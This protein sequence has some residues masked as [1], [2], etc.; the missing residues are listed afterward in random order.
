[1]NRNRSE[2]EF[3]CGDQMLMKVPGRSGCGETP[4]HF[5]E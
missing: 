2:R 4:P 3:K 5:E 1:M